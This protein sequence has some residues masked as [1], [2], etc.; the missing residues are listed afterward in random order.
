M[1]STRVWHSPLLFACVWSFFFVSVFVLV[2]HVVGCLLGIGFLFSLHV[3][4]LFIVLL[5]VFRISMSCMGVYGWVFWTSGY[6]CFS[7]CCCVVCQA[8][9]ELHAIQQTDWSNNV[10]SLCHSLYFSFF[11]QTDWSN[12][13]LCLTLSLSLCLSLSHSMSLSPSISLP[14]SLSFFFLFSHSLSLYI[15]ITL[16]SCR[17]LSLYLYLY[18]SIPPSLSITQPHSLTL[19]F[20][21]SSSL[22]PSLTVSL[23]TSLYLSLLLSPFLI[24]CL[25]LLPPTTPAVSLSHS[26]SLFLSHSLSLSLSLCLSISLS[27]SVPQ[28]PYLYLITIIALPQTVLQP[29]VSE[30]HRP[31]LPFFTSHPTYPWWKAITGLLSLSLIFLFHPTLHSANIA[32]HWCPALKHDHI[33]RC[34]KLCLLLDGKGLFPKPSLPPL[35]FYIILFCFFRLS[36]DLPSVV[37][38][39]LA[40]VLGLQLLRLLLR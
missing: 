35:P 1:L 13:Y 30:S 15:S 27:L 16:S 40:V 34:A 33:L 17:C 4:L 5:L 36:C 10:Q 29:Y 18:H 39:Y 24:P 25:C 21:H 12:L 31:P 11:Q 26:L 37:N 19:T 32:G 20:S 14:P 9:R 22:T 23:S 6:K 2:S 38:I 28:S 3:F 7:C 8:S